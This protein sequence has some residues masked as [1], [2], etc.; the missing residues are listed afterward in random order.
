MILNYFNEIWNDY[1]PDPE[2]VK[3]FLYFFV[4][5]AAGFVLYYFGGIPTMIT[6]FLITFLAYMADTR[7]SE[8]INNGGWFWGNLFNIL[9][10]WLLPWTKYVF[11]ISKFASIG[12]AAALIIRFIW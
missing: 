1:A 3:I 9:F 7:L 5:F 10:G 4:P 8:V 12:T 11:D 2:K 6:I